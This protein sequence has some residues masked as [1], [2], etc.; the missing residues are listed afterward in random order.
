M[1]NEQ[2]LSS[3]ER[4]AALHRTGL[5]GSPAEDR[6]DGFT[7]LAAQILGVPTVV[8]SLVEE[9]SQYFKSACGRNA[10]DLEPRVAAVKF[11]SE[12][13]G[14]EEPLWACAALVAEVSPSPKVLI[15]NHRDNRARGA[16]ESACQ[17]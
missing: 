7:R 8:I 4:L 14:D 2:A 9:H 3:P 13:R 15:P 12:E 6:L 17:R 1:A 5:L 11:D 10:R 16:V